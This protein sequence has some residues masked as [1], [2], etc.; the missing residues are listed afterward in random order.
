MADTP[1]TTG[2]SENEATAEARQRRVERAHERDVDRLIFFTDAV[3]AIALTLLAL[4]IRPDLPLN[5]SD[6]EIRRDLPGKVRDLT[7]LIVTF[8]WSA[9]VLS[10][11]WTLHRRMFA[12]VIR[13][14]GPLVFLNTSF[15]ILIALLPF[16]SYMLGAYTTTTLTD[17]AYALNVGAISLVAMLMWLRAH[18]GNR[19]TDTDLDQRDIRRNAVVSAWPVVVFLASIP[20]AF[21]APD[22]APW[23]WALLV[24]LGP[25]RRWATSERQPLEGPA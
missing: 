7:P 21:V 15:L 3:I 9:F 23:T 2:T 17:I 24:L 8:V 22:W 1:T 20:V 25:L 4:E 14:D 12:H 19:L 6:D 10:G 16:P 11:F 5:L 18:A 13:L